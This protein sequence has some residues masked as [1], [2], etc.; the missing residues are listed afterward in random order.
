MIYG[1]YVSNH[2]S[3]LHN[4]DLGYK[5]WKLTPKQ[6]K[7]KRIYWNDTRS[8]VS[9]KSQQSNWKR[10]ALNS[11]QGSL[12]TSLFVAIVLGHNYF[13]NTYLLPHLYSLEFIANTLKNHYW[14]L[15]FFVTYQMISHRKKPLTTH[16]QVRP[17]KRITLALILDGQVLPPPFLKMFPKEALYSYARQLVKTPPTPTQI[18]QVT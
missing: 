15:P 4:L 3:K 17:E 6:L 11:H 13:V 7:Q 18:I 16:V 2:P 12:L 8:K 10:W 9:L 5:R 14:T 1:L